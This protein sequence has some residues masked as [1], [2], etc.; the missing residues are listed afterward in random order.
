L[1]E[2]SLISSALPAMAVSAGSAMVVAK[3]TRRRSCRPG[4]GCR[5][6]QLHGQAFADGKQAQFQADH[7]HVEPEYHQAETTG[8]NAEVRDGLAQHREVWPS[9]VNPYPTMSIGNSRPT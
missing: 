9:R 4:A 3:P 6:G 2:P 1:I 7:E 8:A 5:S